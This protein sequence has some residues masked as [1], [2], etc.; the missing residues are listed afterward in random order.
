[1]LN[2][3]QIV[4]DNILQFK[5]EKT[6]IHKPKIMIDVAY[7]VYARFIYQMK[8]IYFYIYVMRFDFKILQYRGKLGFGTKLKGEPNCNKYM[9]S[10]F[11]P[12]PSKNYLLY[13][14]N[15]IL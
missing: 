12:N 10:K 6:T 4:Q 2:I 5:N 1:M 7:N 13:I 8:S 15:S 11:V 9:R 14:Y 3:K